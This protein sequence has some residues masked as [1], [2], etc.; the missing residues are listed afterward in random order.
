MRELMEE[1]QEA[2]ELRD[3]Q[4]ENL[5]ILNAIATLE[6]DTGTVR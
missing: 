1:C 6:R 3:R 4:E 2:A 5:R